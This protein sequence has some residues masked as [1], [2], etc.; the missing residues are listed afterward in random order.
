MDLYNFDIIKT[1]CF[2]VKMNNDILSKIKKSITVFEIYDEIRMLLYN[3]PS[4]DINGT[5]TSDSVLYLDNFVPIVD[6]SPFNS[7]SMQSIRKYII[8]KIIIYNLDSYIRTNQQ[9]TEHYKNKYLNIIKNL[10]KNVHL[11]LAPGENSFFQNHYIPYFVND[12]LLLTLSSDDVKLFLFIHELLKYFNSHNQ[13][14]N[15]YDIHYDVLKHIIYSVF[16][17]NISSAL[18]L[19]DIIDIFT[20][21]ISN[22]SPFFELESN[23]IGSSIIIYIIESNKSLLNNFVS[24][25]S[26][27]QNITNS[28]I[29]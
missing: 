9:L 25:F 15:I 24:Y 28:I 12:D 21:I 16:N 20:N 23:Y 19:N 5:Y 22:T 6:I 4:Y 18:F 14:F 1:S 26:L 11:Y 17:S 3:H 29:F 27:Y 8:N 13:H 7:F 10:K 2:S